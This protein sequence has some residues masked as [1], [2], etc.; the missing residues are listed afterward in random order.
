LPGF[1]MGMTVDVFQL[2][3]KLPLHQMLLKTCK[4]T[5][6]AEVGRF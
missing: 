1:K 5:S 4:R 3:G 6:F 2:G